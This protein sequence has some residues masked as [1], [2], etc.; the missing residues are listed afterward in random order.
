M[1]KLIYKTALI[2]LAALAA[3]AIVVFSLWIVISPQTM[4]GACEKTGNYSLAV[5]CADLRYKYT[6]NTDDLARCAEDSILCGKDKLIIK[7]GE[8][9]ISAKDFP[10]VCE[11]RDKALEGNKGG[12]YVGLTGKDVNYNSYIK[13]HLAAA[14][15][16]SGDTDKAIETVKT[17]V[18]G[19]SLVKLVIEISEKSDK[20]A[21]EKLLN[22][23]K[24][25]EQ[26]E[27]ITKLSEILTKI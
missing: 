2:T 16:R 3:I 27:L 14:Q 26:N 21:A 17:D 18:S 23:L 20:Q 4:A 12:E 24:T 25:C 11:A 15:Y 1:N 19:Q 13:S 22:V 8:P 5:T 9:L 10:S 6:K 7:Y